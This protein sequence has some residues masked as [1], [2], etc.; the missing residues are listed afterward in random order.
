MQIADLDPAD[1]RMLHALAILLLEGFRE[2]APSAWPDLE[3]AR[4]EVRAALQ[5][6]RFNR[7]AIGDDGTTAGW[8]G[9][10]PQYGGCVWEVHPLVVARAFQRQGIGRALVTDLEACA[11]A[12]GGLTLLVGTDDETGHTSLSGVDLYANLPQ[13]LATVRSLRR[14]PCGFYRRLGFTIVGVVPDANG[15]GKPDILMAKR[16]ARRGIMKKPL[17]RGRQQSRSGSG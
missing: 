6:D 11:R 13:R 12:R 7:V 4:A 9:G 15:P 10:I 16:I 1:E 3:S 2:S 5:P 8:I 14:H 17:I